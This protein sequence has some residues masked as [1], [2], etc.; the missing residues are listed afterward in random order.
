[1][2][3]IDFAKGTLKELE[4]EVPAT[5]KCIERIPENLY[6]WKPHEKS[7]NLGYLTLLVADIPRWI[8][9]MLENGDI[10][11]ATFNQF[12]LSTNAALVAHFDDN[13][14]AA[15]QALQQG[16]GRGAQQNIPP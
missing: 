10:D 11:F 13:I 2:T 9:H 16:K 6:N 14:R 5:R 1:M 12:Q 3:D 15:K 4:A 7:M 8:A